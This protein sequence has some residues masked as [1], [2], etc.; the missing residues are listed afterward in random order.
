M[1]EELRDERRRHIATATLALAARAGVEAISLR[2]VAREAE[3]STGQIQYQFGTVADLTLFALGQVIEDLEQWIDGAPGAD[4]TSPPV[5]ATPGSPTTAPTTGQERIRSWALRLLADDPRVVSDLR[6]YAQLRGVA[7]HDERIAEVVGAFSR[8]RQAEL[9]TL[10][11][12]AKQKRILHSLVDP[13]HEAEVFWTLMLSVA[14]EVAQ[15]LRDRTRGRE[16]LRYHF[17]RLARNERVTRR[18]RS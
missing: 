15:G 17:I 4:D 11:E 1:R 6:A 3:T 9:R 13:E 10:L 7:A 12:A 8:R 18:P 14:I 2:N 5:T 16:M